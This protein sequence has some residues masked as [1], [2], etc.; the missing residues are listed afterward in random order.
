[1]KFKALIIFLILVSVVF[2]CTNKEKYNPDSHLTVLEQ[3]SIV[4]RMM[5]YIARPPE[6]LL[7]EERFYKGYDKYYHE[8]QALHKLEAYYIDGQKTHYFMLTRK[9]PSLFGKYVATGGKM[10]FTDK[11]KLVE[12]EEVFRTWKMIPDTL[13]RRSMFLFDK[14]VKG[15][16]LTPYYTEN[17]NG[18]E[19]IE[20]PDKRNYFDIPSRRWKQKEVPLN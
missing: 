12:Y 10:K 4:W 1:M 13:K 9:A 7:Y 19:Y 15:E 6:G 14:M 17:S 3:D 5:R 2:R 8:Q 20:F 16:A 18:V 11:G